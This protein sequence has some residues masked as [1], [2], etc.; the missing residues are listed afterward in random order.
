LVGDTL[1][2]QPVEQVQAI[3]EPLLAQKHV[4]VT[5]SLSQIQFIGNVVLN[6]EDQSIGTI[7]AAFKEN[8]VGV[9]YKL[10]NITVKFKE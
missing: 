1:I 6:E 2:I 3:S 9:K 5:S 4:L 10:L 7:T 8:P